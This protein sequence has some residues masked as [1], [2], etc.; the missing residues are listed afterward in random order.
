[1]RERERRERERKR[2]ES[3]DSVGETKSKD[4]NSVPIHTPYIWPLPL[5]DFVF[6]L[7]LSLKTSVV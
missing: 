5:N 3:D 7:N 6:G 4:A 1:M 2:A